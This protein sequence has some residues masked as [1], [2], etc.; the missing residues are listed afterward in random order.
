MAHFGFD[1]LQPFSE[2]GQFGGCDEDH[3]ELDYH[4][5][6]EFKILSKLFTRKVRRPFDTLALEATHIVLLQD[7]R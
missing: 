5:T 4:E 2:L 3:V 1:I 6:C 7:L